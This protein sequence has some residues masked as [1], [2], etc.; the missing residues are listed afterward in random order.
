MKQKAKPQPTG[1]SMKML[2][3][4]AVIGVMA[5]LTGCG[6]HWGVPRVD[7]YQ[8]IAKAAE[9]RDKNARIPNAKSQTLA[10][11][12]SDSTILQLNYLGERYK[13]AVAR[14]PANPELQE[15]IKPAYYVDNIM[16][17]LRKHFNN[18]VVVKNFDM[19]RTYLKIEN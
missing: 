11:V 4:I 6:G 3:L 15:R 7:P 5:S 13:Q 12:V 18:I 19:A 17:I 2:K 10:L 8:G 14:Y 9:V 1:D 16:F